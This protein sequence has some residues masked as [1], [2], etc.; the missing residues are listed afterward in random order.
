LEDGRTLSDYKIEKESTVHLIL[1]DRVEKGAKMYIN[2]KT[3]TGKI[4]PLDVEPNDTIESVKYKIQDKERIPV[5][6]QRLIYAGRQL[7]D[8]RTVSDYK[9]ENES[10]V[11]IVLRLRGFVA[12]DV[13]QNKVKKTGRNGYH[14]YFASPGLNYG[15]TCKKTTCFAYQEPVIC[16]RGFGEKI[17]PIEDVDGVRDGSFSGVKCPGCK[18]SFVVDNY[19]LYRC[20]AMVTFKKK[21]QKKLS[22]SHQRVTGDEVWQL[23]GKTDDTGGK[24]EYTTLIFDVKKL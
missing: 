4:I 22:K 11:H 20:N 10:T 21:G 2:F 23:G 17:R 9:I 8:G 19:F 5:A 16:T 18:K 1:R 24:A 7:D 3:I 14:Y 12:P 15:G 6:Q 13:D